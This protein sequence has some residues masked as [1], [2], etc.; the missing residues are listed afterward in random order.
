MLKT[1][2]KDAAV[3][4]EAPISPIDAIAAHHAE[5]VAELRRRVDDLLAVVALNEPAQPAAAS[6]SDYLHS[7]LLPH[8]AS[9]EVTLYV[10]AAHFEPRLVQSL[11][12]EHGTL[13]RLVAELA[14]GR[15]PVSRAATACAIVELFAAHAA[16]ENDYVLPALLEGAPAELPALVRSMHEEFESRLRP[17]VVATLDV[18]RLPH[19]ARHG[20]IFARLEAL[21]DGEALAIVNDH[22]PI[23]LRH[24]L[25]ALRPGAF[26]WSYEESGPELWRVV[27]TRQDGARSP[28]AL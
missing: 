24:Q 9:E 2:E 5:M 18:R 23:P 22:D 13:R 10:A 12:A 8:A 19:A 14:G 20:Q 21:G 16:K 11:I 28:R 4:T 1:N 17:R 7:T 6:V 25:D 15:Q 26:S 27:I 3:P